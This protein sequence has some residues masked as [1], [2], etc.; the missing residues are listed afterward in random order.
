MKHIIISIII[1][2]M[3]SISLFAQTKSLAELKTQLTQIE[4]EQQQI[5]ILPSTMEK[6]SVGLAILYSALLPGMGELYAGNYGLGKYLTIAD[7]VFWGVF[8]GLNIY[9]NQQE[10]NYRSFATSY[11]GANTDGKD[12]QFF[13]DMADY[14]SVEQYNE[15][16]KLERN[17]DALYNTETHYWE[18][19][20][21]N[22]RREYRGMWSDSENAFNNVRFAVGALVL[23]R[24]V[25]VI[26]AVRLVARHNKQV[27]EELN[28]N[29]SVGMDNNPNL[30]TSL[31]LN[32]HHK[33]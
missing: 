22:Q 27:G 17:F 20:D 3:L 13:A 31:Q 1:S 24:V 25:S 8:A 4:T 26:N 12:D 21:N 29:M 30:P 9:G 7:G 28:W 33:F 18:W 10:D 2:L 6:K 11:G 32:F 16:K 5:E 15:A 23:N 19:N 14:V